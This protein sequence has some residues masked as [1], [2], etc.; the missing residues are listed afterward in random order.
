M[1]CIQHSLTCKVS[2]IHS[3]SIKDVTLCHW[4]NA[5][6]HFECTTFVQNT[7]KHL[8]SDEAL[9]P[10]RPKPQTLNYNYTPLLDIVPTSTL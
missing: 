2:G 1:K 5:S 3:A 10:K 8:P 6:Q 9:H 4:V 7:R